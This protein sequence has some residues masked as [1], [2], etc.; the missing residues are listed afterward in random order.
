MVTLRFIL[1]RLKYIWV[2]LPLLTVRRV[3]NLLKSIGY[4]LLKSN[5]STKVP[6]ILILTVTSDCN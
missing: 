1:G 5:R 4:F 3:I 2:L 6:P